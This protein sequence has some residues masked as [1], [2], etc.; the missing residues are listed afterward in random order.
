M[1]I[2][3]VNRLRKES[4]LS[5]IKNYGV[6]YDQTWIFDKVGPSWTERRR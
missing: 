2:E 1:Q 6:D 5:T 4:V 3:V